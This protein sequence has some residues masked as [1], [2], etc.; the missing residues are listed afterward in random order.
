MRAKISTKIK[1]QRVKNGY[2][3]CGRGFFKQCA[4]CSLILENGIKTHKC[5]ITKET[6][7]TNNPVTCISKNVICRT[8]CKKAQCK[9]FVYKGQFYFYVTRDLTKFDENYFQDK[10]IDI[11]TVIEI[12]RKIVLKVHWSIFNTAHFQS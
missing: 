3:R 9:D 1:S 12:S 7:N 2:S 5:Q 11:A 6:Y 8:T 10:E 4:T